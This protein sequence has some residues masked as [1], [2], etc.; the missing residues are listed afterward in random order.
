MPVAYFWG[1][2]AT[3]CEADCGWM[4]KPWAITVFVV[5]PI[6]LFL[7]SS[8]EFL[9]AALRRIIRWWRS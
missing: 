1:L 2:G 9:I 3:A 4:A 6:W 8:V 5:I 7:F